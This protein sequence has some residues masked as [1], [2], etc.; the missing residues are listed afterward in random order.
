MVFMDD[1]FGVFVWV[2]VYIDFFDEDLL[3]EDCGFV[4]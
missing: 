3:V 2:E 4:C 1:L